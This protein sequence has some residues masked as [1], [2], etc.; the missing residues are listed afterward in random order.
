MSITAR[1]IAITARQIAI[2][3]RQIAITAHQ[4]AHGSVSVHEAHVRANP[5][6]TSLCM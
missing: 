5:N 6:C 4:I 2:T 1:Q 3:A